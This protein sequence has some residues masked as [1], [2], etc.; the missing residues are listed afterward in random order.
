MVDCGATASFINSLFAQLHGLKLIPMQHPRDLTVAV[1]RIISS[2]ATTHTVTVQ[3]SFALG[4]HT[5]VLKHFITTCY[6]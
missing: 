1:G 5:E 6:K 2:G 3:T 4:A